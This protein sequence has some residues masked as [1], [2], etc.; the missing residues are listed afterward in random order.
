MAYSILAHILSE[1][2]LDLKTHLTAKEAAIQLW[3]KR[4]DL[5]GQLLVLDT[6]PKEKLAKVFIQD[7]IIKHLLCGRL[8]TLIENAHT[9][10]HTHMQ[11][12]NNNMVKL[13]NLINNQRCKIKQQ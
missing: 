11:K 5:N 8:Y 7:L 2:A 4:T 6:I 9:H 10:T 3:K 12:G 1:R 13:F